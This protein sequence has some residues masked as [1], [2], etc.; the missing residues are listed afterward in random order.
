MDTNMPSSVVY[1]K[2]YLFF[3]T[4]P[5]KK[6]TYVP[7]ISTYPSPFLKVYQPTLKEIKKKSHK[8]NYFETQTR[9]M[10]F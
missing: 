8:P 10:L 2:C 4:L 1:G 6:K 9:P 7:K 3:L 5:K